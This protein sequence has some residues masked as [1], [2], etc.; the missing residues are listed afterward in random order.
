MAFVK[1]W[2][3]SLVLTACLPLFVLVGGC[4]SLFMS[5]MSGRAQ[6]AYAEAGNVLEQ[7]V[8]GIR[9]V[10]YCNYILIMK[11]LC[12]RQSL[13][14][15]SSVMLYLLVLIGGLIHWRK[16]SNSKL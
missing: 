9:T 15:F 4:M 5:R 13:F 10:K 1:G 2:L 16:A 12:N 8:G 6:V 11:L 14:T 3:L 7:T